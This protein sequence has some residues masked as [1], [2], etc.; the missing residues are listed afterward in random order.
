MKYLLS[1]ILL[2]TLSCVYCSMFTTQDSLWMEEALAELSLSAQDLMFLKDWSDET[3]LKNDII[4]NA[5][6]NPYYF[7]NYAKKWDKIAEPDDFHNLAYKFLNNNELKLTYPAPVNNLLTKKITVSQLKDIIESYLTIKRIHFEHAFLNLT[8]AE[9]ELIKSFVN[10]LFIQ[11]NHEDKSTELTALEI[12]EI[13]NKINWYIFY[14]PVVIENKSILSKRLVI[15]SL[16]DFILLNMNN[17]NWSEENQ[18]FETPLGEIIIGSIYD[19]QHIINNAIAIVDPAGNDTYTFESNNQEVFFLFDASGNDYYRSES[20][21]FSA[22]FGFSFAYDMAGDDIYLA[23]DEAFSAK[24]G[25]QE[26]I[27]FAGNDYYNTEMFSLGA[28]LFGSSLVIDKSGDDTYITGEYGQGF[29]SCWGIS[30]LLD[31]AGSDTYICGT[32][33][34]HA[35]LVPNDYRSMGQGMGFGIRPDLAGGVGVLIDRE[36][37]DRY[38]GGVY[39][40]GVGYWYGLG[41]LIDNAGNDF[42]SAVYYPQGSGI[43][44]AGGLLYDQQGEDSY[45]S[46]HG[47]GQGAGHDFG[48][49]IF[50]DGAGNDHYSI[51]GGNGLGI[52]NSVGIFIDKA[53]ND[54]YENGVNSNYGFGKTAR[55]S[56]SI[57]IFLDGGGK[58]YY[59][60]TTMQDST[61]WKQGVY[62]I[63]IDSEQ[64]ATEPIYNTKAKQLSADIDSLANIEIIFNYASEWEVGNVINRVRRA[65]QI[66]LNREGE[67]VDYIIEHKM[68]TRDTKEYRAI[69]EF[70]EQSITSQYR[71]VDPLI[72]ED[73]LANKNAISLVSA[74]EM[75][76]YIP[77]ILSFY[78]NK[79]YTLACI[80]ALASFKDDTY[81]PY[82]LRYLSSPNEKLRFAV[83]NALKSID[84]ELARKE[85]AVMKKDSSFLVRTLAIEHLKIK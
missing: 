34:F 81:I 48:V 27:D 2:L 78:E 46:K 83:A 51:E 63:G 62:G 82:I 41:I 11:Q 32:L 47:P 28:S 16:K 76:E 7:I 26:F 19:D 17:I 38:I 5:I 67:S 49:G 6:N 77:L 65:R 73:S 10:T 35:P 20:S 45:Y 22:N 3:Y 14:Q 52:S 42:Y 29:A 24:L 59:P 75:D 58:D 36:G 54:R 53:G 68:S 43:H 12:E 13:A 84:S 4:V 33:E 57:G 69:K 39:T 72:A 56:G 44:L 30:L 66:L 60:Y 79:Q 40:Q 64:Y 23:K 1:L 31:E 37:N 18:Y 80:S 74:L 85:L 25:F 61:S 50:I 21:L 8:P 9:L 71:L 70:F 55:S 15:N